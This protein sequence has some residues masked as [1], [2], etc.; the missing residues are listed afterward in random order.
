[1]Q[2]RRYLYSHLDKYLTSQ[3]CEDAQNLDLENVLCFIL[4][5]VF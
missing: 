2:F 1:M 4:M 5:F 3:T